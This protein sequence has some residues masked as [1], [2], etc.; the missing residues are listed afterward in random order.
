MD[1][2]FHS[3]L[4]SLSEGVC[5]ISRDWQVLCFNRAAEAMLGIARQDALG[6]NFDE[7]IGQVACE[8]RSAIDQVMRKGSTLEN[9]NLTLHPTPE[10]SIPVQLNVAPVITH[11]D[12]SSGIVITF[13]DVSDLEV[14]RREL[15]EEYHHGDIVSKSPLMQRILAILPDVARSD[16]S[17]LISGASGTGKELL[18]RALHHESSRRGKR[19][20]A[21][22][23]G[24]LPENLIESELFGYV[25]GAFT[26]AKRNKPGRF[27]LAEGGTLFLDEIGDLPLALQVKLLRVLQ[28]KEYEPLGALEP[29]KTNVRIVA[30]SHRNLET[31]IAEGSFREDLFYRLSII[32]LRLPLL[33]ERREDIPLLIEYFLKRFNAEKGR[34]VRRISPAA[35][36][37][38]MRYEFPGNIRELQNAI[39]HAYVLC[40]DDEILERCLPPRILETEEPSCVQIIASNKN[41]SN[42]IA[43]GER[44]IILQ[45]LYENEGHRGRTAAALGIDTSTLWRKMKKFGIQ[46]DKST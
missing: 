35:L 37:R 22:N 1:S 42:I 13:R 6:K 38:L 43:K 44:D 29:L 46:Y 17:A 15:N 23:C 36:H 31:M 39:E 21:V 28:E 34:H 24:A 4:N 45:T 41:R 3:V 30:A 18:A 33:S 16:S 2:F 11:E 14:L 40:R 26:D 8:F 20:V 5:T 27:A 10:R 25:K 9:L 32:Q 12:E 7:T 19:F